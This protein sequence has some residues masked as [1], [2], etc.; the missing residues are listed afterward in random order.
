MTARVD[1]GDKGIDPASDLGQAQNEDAVVVSSQPARVPGVEDAKSMNRLN[2]DDLIVVKS[3]IEC[4][5]CFCSCSSAYNTTLF[6]P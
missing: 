3:S 4:E 2:Y 1:V 5:Y 6:V